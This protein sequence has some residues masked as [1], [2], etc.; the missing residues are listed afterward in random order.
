MTLPSRA[1]LPDQSW[2]FTPDLRSGFKSCVHP[3]QRKGSSDQNFG[4]RSKICSSGHLDEGLAAI[5]SKKIHFFAALQ[6]QSVRYYQ[7]N[8]YALWPCRGWEV[9]KAG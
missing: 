2:R 9:S 1:A 5:W 7:Q 3:E 8:E 4:Q 6:T